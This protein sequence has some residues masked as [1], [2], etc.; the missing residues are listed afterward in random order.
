MTKEQQL[1]SKSIELLYDLLNVASN[2]CIKYRRLISACKT[3]QGL[4]NYHDPKLGIISMSLN[5]FKRY[6]NNCTKNDITFSAIDLLRK[7]VTGGSNSSV[8]NHTPKTISE[9]K[10]AMRLAVIY[11]YNELMKI[12][13][14]LILN[15]DAAL[16]DFQLHIEKFRGVIGISEVGKN[17]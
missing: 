16:E 15:D 8:T 9:N 12:A 17:G 7:E 3:Q 1:K 11:A 2:D 14:P 4:A 13:K 10:D 5:T 6:A